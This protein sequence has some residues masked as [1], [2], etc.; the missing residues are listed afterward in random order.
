MPTHSVQVHTAVCATVVY[1]THDPDSDEDVE[2]ISV[3][4]DGATDGALFSD[5]ED[6]AW[7]EATDEWVRVPWRVMDEGMAAVSAA[8]KTTSDG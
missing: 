8:I 6:K 3:T 5:A 1:A 7:E 2:I 4:F